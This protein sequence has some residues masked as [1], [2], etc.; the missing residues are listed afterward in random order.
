MYTNP[1]HYLLTVKFYWMGSMLRLITLSKNK[2][3][4]LMISNLLLTYS[5]KIKS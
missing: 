5:Q 3:D 2:K 4:V 1:E